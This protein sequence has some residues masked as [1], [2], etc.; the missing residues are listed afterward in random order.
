MLFRSALILCKFSGNDC[1]TGWNK[2]ASYGKLSN[3]WKRAGN[4]V[5]NCEGLK[6]S[7]YVEGNGTV[8]N[9]DANSCG[10]SGNPI[11]GY[12]DASS[13]FGNHTD[14]EEGCHD[15]V[16]IGQALT[17]CNNYYS[18]CPLINEAKTRIFSERGCF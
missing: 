14:L 6:D 13:T 12:C 4:T 10:N 7:P 18:P 9:Y 11:P 3:T 17:S 5:S 15:T 2:Y 16:N 8:S 1:H